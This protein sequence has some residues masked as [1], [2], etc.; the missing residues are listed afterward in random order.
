MGGAE[1][2]REGIGRPSRLDERGFRI[3]QIGEIL[4]KKSI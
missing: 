4:Y 3:L 1:E 2:N